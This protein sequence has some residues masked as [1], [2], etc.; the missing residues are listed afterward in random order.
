MQEDPVG[1]SSTDLAVIGR[2]S[3]AWDSWQDWRRRHPYLSVAVNSLAAF[4]ILGAAAGAVGFVV[5]L[6]GLAIAELF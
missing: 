2:R 6:V 4:V 1:A 3:S 5:W